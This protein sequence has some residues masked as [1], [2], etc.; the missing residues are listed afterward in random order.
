[1]ESVITLNQCRTIMKAS[2]FGY[3]TLVWIF[4]GNRTLNNAM[5]NIQE[6]A[7]RLVYA[8]YNSSFDQLLAKDS[9]YGIHHLYLQRLAVEIYKFKNNLCPEIL[10]EMCEASTNISNTRW[11]TILKTRNVKCL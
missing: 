10:N 2:Q 6:R 4:D 5:D 11:G 7:L 9:S 8:D 3:C 1:M